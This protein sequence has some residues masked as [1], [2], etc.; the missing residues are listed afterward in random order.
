M[1]PA[2]AVIQVPRLDPTGL[3]RLKPWGCDLTAEFRD[4]DERGD[5]GLIKR[6]RSRNAR[7]LVPDPDIL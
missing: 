2:P 3:T 1:R 6:D 4:T 7:D 5:R